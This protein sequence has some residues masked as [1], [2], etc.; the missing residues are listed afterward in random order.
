MKMIIKN[1]IDRGQFFEV[2]PLFAPNV[3]TGLGEVEG[4]SVGFVANQ[5]EVLA[6]CIDISASEKAARFVRFCDA[7]NI[8]LVFFSD[9]PG[10]LPG[11]NWKKEASSSM[12]PNG[13]LP[14]LRPL[15][16]RSISSPGSS[17]EEPMGVMS[18][19]EFNG[20]F[21]YAWP[22]AEVAVMGAKGAVEI[23]FRGKN[24]EHNIKKYEEAFANPLV[25]SKNGIIDD[26]VM[27]D[28]T[29][30]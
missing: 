30:A 1:V 4:R 15:S 19:K 18:P 3:V 11:V 20:D 5:P 22:T 10:F 24:P 6:G 23:L 7:F 29:R 17:M 13:C 8:P 9:V 27:P 25:A 12:E 28:M 2:M 26:I 16:L 21:N 14:S